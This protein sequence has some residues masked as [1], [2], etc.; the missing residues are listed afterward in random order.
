MGDGGKAGAPDVSTAG[1][2]SFGKVEKKR[3]DLP[4]GYTPGALGGDAAKSVLSF[5]RVPS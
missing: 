1:A 4:R 2:V 5:I 3:E